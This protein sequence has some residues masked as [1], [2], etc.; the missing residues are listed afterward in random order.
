M[1]KVKCNLLFCMIMVLT[2]LCISAC[3]EGNTD[4]DKVS[5]NGD[6]DSDIQKNEKDLSKSEQQDE[7]LPEDNQANHGPYKVMETELGYY[8]NLGLVNSV[9]NEKGLTISNR[10]NLMN[11][12]FFDKET[13]IAV[14]L[15]DKPE[16]HHQQTNDCVATYNKLWVIGQDIYDGY[17]YTY[18][19]ERDDEISRFSLYRTALD[20]SAIDRV[21]VVME[22]EN[23]SE[24]A[25]IIKPDLTLGDFGDG[26]IIHKGYAYLPY[27]LRVGT[28][29]KGFK[30]GGIK[31]MNLK[32]GETETVFEMPDS[33]GR[34][35][36]QMI[37]DGDYIYF[38][39]IDK[40]F[41]QNWFRYDTKT[42][43]YEK[44]PWEKKCK[45]L[46]QAIKNSIIYTVLTEENLE[47][48]NKAEK[49]FT[50]KL[51]VYKITDDESVEQI[52][53]IEINKSDRA[54]YAGNNKGILVYKDYYVVIHGEKLTVYSA[55]PENFG[56][57]LGELAYDAEWSQY[58]NEYAEFKINN[59]KIYRVYQKPRLEN[60]EWDKIGHAERGPYI[61][62]GRF[63]QS[64]PIED[65]I[66]G[67]GEWT[68]SYRTLFEES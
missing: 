53:E 34:Y 24:S 45:G 12:F 50:N 8:Y 6:N 54:A 37:G 29:M 62:H 43:I 27:Y 10:D 25:Y 63:Y 41:Q 13:G 18:G 17:L 28:T 21:G 1:K 30:G 39:M 9:Q 46:I 38:L 22:A 23:K 16:C 55:K 61:N 2:I 11:M 44:N 31:R 52:C 4:S 48:D 64:C 58:S 59:D 14:Q 36:Y 26:M 3:G 20:G 40:H 5:T 35:P 33:N 56:N 51:L 47:N 60:E 68:E 7:E 19:E 42:G 66:K 32:T 67:K 57:V 65:I 15:C 49:R